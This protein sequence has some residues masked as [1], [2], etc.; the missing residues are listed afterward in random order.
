MGL[1]LAWKGPLFKDVKRS[2]KKNKQKCLAINFI[3][4]RKVI[5]DYKSI[6]NLINI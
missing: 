1:K 6:T 4:V 3:T 2:A 5:H